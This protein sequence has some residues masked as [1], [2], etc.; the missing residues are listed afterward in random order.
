MKNSRDS[1]LLISI[2]ILLCVLRF[3]IRESIY[4]NEIMAVINIVALNYSIWCMFNDSEII[5]KEKREK[6]SIGKEV[7]R[8]KY[9]SLKYTRWVTQGIIFIACSLFYLVVMKGP[10]GNDILTI[11]ALCFTLEANNFSNKIASFFYKK[12]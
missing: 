7:F 6:S 4:L 2:A 12:K 11:I 3:L 5:F 10:T 1:G 9:K 8:S